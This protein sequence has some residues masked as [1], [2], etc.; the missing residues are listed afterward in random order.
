MDIPK[1]LEAINE[2]ESWI[3]SGETEGYDDKY[4]QLFFLQDLVFEL[5]SAVSNALA[6]PLVSA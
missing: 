2:I 3:A 5:K 6:N 1:A 4:N